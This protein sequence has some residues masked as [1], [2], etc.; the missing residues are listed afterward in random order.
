MTDD[1]LKS[2]TYWKHFKGGVYKITAIATVEATGEKVVVYESVSKGT[3]W[4]RP[5]HGDKG[6]LSKATTTDGREVDRFTP[7]DLYDPMV[8]DAFKL[9]RQLE[10]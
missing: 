8:M 9:K 6:W 3:T 5:P 4:I 2:K 7:L 10:S 1:D